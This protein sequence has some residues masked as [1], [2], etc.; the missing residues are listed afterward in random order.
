LTAKSADKAGVAINVAI[1][2]PIII[3]FMSSPQYAGKTREKLHDQYHK[4]ASA[5]VARFA[6]GTRKSAVHK[7]KAG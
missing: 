7:S 1:A 5:T 4:L 2:A 3:D 6:T